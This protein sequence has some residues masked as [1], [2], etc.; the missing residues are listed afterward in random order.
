MTRPVWIIGS[1]LAGLITAFR[2]LPYGFH[3][4]ILE[5]RTAPQVQDHTDV[6]PPVWPGFFHAT[7]SL[8]QE[9]SLPL[10][11]FHTGPIE[12][13]SSDNQRYR[14]P[15]FPIF[16][17]MHVCPELLLSQGLSWRDRL[18]LLNHLEK[19]WESGSSNEAISDT[20]T[21]E[22]WI[23]A[24]NQSQSARQHF[25][26]PLCRWLLGC[27]LSEASLRM[28]VTTLSRYAQ[29]T[30]T[31]TQWF[32]GPDSLIR[33]LKAGLRELLIKQ[34]V[35]FHTCEAYPPFRSGRRNVEYLFPAGDAFS[36]TAT[37]VA[38]L[39]PEEIL[40]L[41]PERVLTKFAQLDR[42]AHILSQTRLLMTFT[43]PNI[44]LSPSLILGP[45]H[46]DWMAIVPS[47]DSL[48]TDTQVVCLLQKTPGE[49]TSERHRDSES[50]WAYLQA[51]LHVTQHL[52]DTVCPPQ[53]QLQQLR[54]F[55]S[56]IGSRAFRPQHTVS[57]PNFFFVGPW[58]DTSFHHSM[59]SLVNSANTCAEAIA[60]RFFSYLR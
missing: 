5:R 59:E 56:S 48:L 18:N 26:N 29:T 25:W 38:A 33:E 60:H 49:S 46:I 36:E 24:A 1:S 43:L 9:L 35:Q 28:F 15:R 39:P 8:L 6:L 31:G 37:Y 53:F 21:A 12:V 57:I 17:T 47:T 20:Q 50:I 32:F 34:G 52:P 19:G 42:M 10:P 3:L 27:E 55:P 14:I 58:A 41:L 13:L 11:A 23:K 44:R 4:C 22:T 2:L 51:I 40:P 16:S 45:H 7:W 54:Q 30:S